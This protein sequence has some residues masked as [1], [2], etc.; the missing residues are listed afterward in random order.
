MAAPL[1]TGRRRWWPSRVKE[2]EYP[3]IDGSAS[4]EYPRIDP[5]ARSLAR[6]PHNWER[7]GTS[8]RARR[9]KLARRGAK[10]PLAMR[11]TSELVRRGA[12]TTPS[13]SIDGRLYRWAA[14]FGIR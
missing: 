1:M 8:S 11:A 10:K 4:V 12:S 13:R 2:V 9:V 5:C 14:C 6:K 3:C 7:H